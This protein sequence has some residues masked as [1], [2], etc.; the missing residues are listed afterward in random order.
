MLEFAV[1]IYSVLRKHCNDFTFCQ[2]LVQVKKLRPSQWSNVQGVDYVSPCHNKN[3]K[4]FV[5]NFLLG[6][7]E[8]GKLD[9]RKRV[10]LD[11]AK[12][13]KR[14]FGWENNKKYYWQKKYWGKGKFGKVEMGKERT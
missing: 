10:N 7:R 8:F 9:I 5:Q 13:R 14:K 6:K 11:K 4:I 1:V 3:K 2:T 12:L